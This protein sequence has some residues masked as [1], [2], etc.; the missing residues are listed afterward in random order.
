MSAK[1]INRE[2]NEVCVSMQQRLIYN[3]NTINLKHDDV[4][5]QNK[6]AAFALWDV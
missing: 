3:M 4:T 5:N 1:F 6:P 2:K